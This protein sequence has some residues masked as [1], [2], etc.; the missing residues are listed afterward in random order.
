MSKNDVARGMKITEKG[1]AKGLTLKPFT[2]QQRPVMSR[3]EE[4]A[5]TPDHGLAWGCLEDESRSLWW[6]VHCLCGWK[7]ETFYSEEGTASTAGQ[8]HLAEDSS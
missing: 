2:P 1:K 8:Q 7:A 5:I 3:A 4:R 6:E